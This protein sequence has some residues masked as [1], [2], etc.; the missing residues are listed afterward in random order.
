MILNE[1]LNE[2]K[3]FVNGVGAVRYTINDKMAQVA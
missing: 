3:A 2:A 1:G